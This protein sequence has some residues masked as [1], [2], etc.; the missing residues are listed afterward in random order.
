MWTN[1]SHLSAVLVALSFWGV[2]RFTRATGGAYSK[3]KR[4]SLV[5]GLGW[6]A[7]LLWALYS[8]P[9]M[10]PFG[11]TLTVTLFAENHYRAGMA[12]CLG[13]ATFHERVIEVLHRCGVNGFL[14][15]ALPAP[16]LQLCLAALLLGLT[17]GPREWFYWAVLGFACAHVL[18][19]F[20]TVHFAL[21]YRL[22]GSTTP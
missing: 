5:L 11:A 14:R 1:V 12:Q 22:G 3:P 2:L 6:L 9:G 21:K 4:L 7:L 20:S 18:Q 19:V 16:L 17:G 15:A 8:Y 10:G 13:T